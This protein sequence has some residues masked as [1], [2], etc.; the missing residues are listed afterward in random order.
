[1]GIQPD[2][3]RTGEDRTERQAGEEV[4]KGVQA[5]TRLA[6]SVQ[7]RIGAGGTLAKCSSGRVTHWLRILQ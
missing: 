5:D 4:G 3:E 2:T 6:G 7:G 1:M